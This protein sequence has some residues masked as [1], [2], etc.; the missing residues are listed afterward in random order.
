MIKESQT[1][2]E[3]CSHACQ[4]IALAAIGGS[5]PGCGGAGGGGVTGPSSAA[6]LPLVNASFANNAVV[7]TIDA[8]SPL[9]SVGS[10]A[11]VQSAAGL[12]LVAHTGQDTFTALTSNCTHAQCTITGYESQT[13]VCPCHGSRFDT[14]GHVRNG[15]AVAA[16]RAY[17]TQFVNPVLT[18]TA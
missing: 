9:A 5:L 13:Y 7:L 16:L 1:R 12:F 6:A 8:S 3:F 10:A 2:R 15:P 18:I 14:S 11:I 4:A 17:T